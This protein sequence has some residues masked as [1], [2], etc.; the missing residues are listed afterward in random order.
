MTT[1]TAELV[2]QA[3]G[4]RETANPKKVYRLRGP[5]RTPLPNWQGDQSPE[6]DLHSGDQ[7]SVGRQSWLQL[8]I[9]PFASLTL[10]AVS[11]VI[12]LRH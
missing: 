4:L 5:E 6:S 2:A 3:G 11:L 1:T 10:A 7:I 8:N 12:T 9:I